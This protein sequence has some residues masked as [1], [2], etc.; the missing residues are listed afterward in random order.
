M[1]VASA[2]DIA[3]QVFADGFCAGV[4]GLTQKQWD[5]RKKNQAYRAANLER[6]REHYRRKR[7]EARAARPPRV[8]KG[9]DLEK[10]A[11][12]AKAYYQK[13]RERLIAEAVKRNKRNYPSYSQW[14]DEKRAKFCIIK[15]K[16]RRKRG[17]KRLQDHFTAHVR[18]WKLHLRARPTLHD[19]H[20][21]CFRM[22]SSRVYRWRYQHDEEFRLKE[23]VRRQIKKKKAPYSEL[24]ASAVWSALRKGAPGK[25]LEKLVGYTMHELRSHLESQF[26]PGMSWD[27]H[28]RQGWHIDH[29]LPKRCFDLTTVEG[30]RDYWRLS[31]LRPLWAKDNIA[32][33]E[34]IDIW[35]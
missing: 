4:L 19:A 32:K 15:Q 2:G 28:G 10:R 11:A 26:L 23:I 24:V 17:L 9:R 22:C 31:N 13:N 27:A 5:K 12:Y 7:E 35:A 34:K 21:K 33:G 18:A 30:A 25:K 1:T 20:V 8:K 16:A 14:S 6:L 29:I 3:F